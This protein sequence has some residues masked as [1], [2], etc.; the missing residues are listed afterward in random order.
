MQADDLVHMLFS[1]EDVELPPE[2]A[3]QTEEPLAG[4]AE[5]SKQGA[6]SG[7]DEL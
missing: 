2:Q 1:T 6:T 4:A 7:K 3:P 5:A